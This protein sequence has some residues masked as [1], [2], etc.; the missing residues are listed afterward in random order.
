[1]HRMHLDFVVKPLQ[2]GWTVSLAGGHS[3]RFA[4]RLAALRSANDDAVRVRRLGHE[5]ALWVD[6]GD[7]RL[8]RL[9]DRLAVREEAAR[10]HP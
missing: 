4:S 5:V 2:E 9:P 1:M 3:G 8:R 7:R 10:R 6:R